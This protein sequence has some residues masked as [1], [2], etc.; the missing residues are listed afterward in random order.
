MSEP[1]TTPEV[2]DTLGTV[3]DKVTYGAG[4]KLTDGNYGSYDFHCSMSTEI[5]PG[6]AAKDAVKRSIAFVEM[7]IEHKAQSMTKKKL[8]Y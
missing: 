7:V 3:G 6:E 8:K 2:A 4:R 5:R 1:E